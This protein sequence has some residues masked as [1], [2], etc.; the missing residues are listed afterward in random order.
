ME[1]EYFNI[2][3][4]AEYLSISKSSL[5]SKVSQ[6]ELPHYKIGHTVRFKKSEIDEWLQTKK[7]HPL[8]VQNKASVI[9]NSSKVDV[10]RLIKKTIDDVTDGR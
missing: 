3:E 7:Q 6:R 4:L 1:K 5:Y 10:D 9:M 2:R 8:N